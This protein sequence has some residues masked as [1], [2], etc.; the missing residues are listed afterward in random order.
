MREEVFAVTSVNSETR[1]FRLQGPMFAVF[2]C[3]EQKELQGEAGETGPFLTY[4]C[5]RVCACGHVSCSSKCLAAS[6]VH[7]KHLS[8]AGTSVDGMGLGTLLVLTK[9]VKNLKL[10]CSFNKYFL[11]LHR[12]PGLIRSLG[13]K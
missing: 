12:S 11:S 1:F 5:V 9:A 8:D 4:V 7:S 6:I 10:N 2:L 13:T 3:S